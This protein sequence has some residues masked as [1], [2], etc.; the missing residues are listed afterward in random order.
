LIPTT[1]PRLDLGGLGLLNTKNK[2][3]KK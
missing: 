1:W 2:I 3:K